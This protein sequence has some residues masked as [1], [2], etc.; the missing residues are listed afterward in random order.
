MINLPTNIKNFGFVERE[1]INQKYLL[2]R[3]GRDFLYYA[4]HYY[5]PN[6]FNP[7]K[8]NPK[9]IESKKLFGFSIPAVFAWTQF[10]F[11]NLPK[12]LKSKSLS[13]KINNKQIDTF[14]DFLIA[15]LFSRIKYVE[16]VKKVE[17]NVKRG[18]V[19]GLDI[20]MAF[21]GLLDHVLFVYG[22]DENY[23]Y[24]CDTRKVPLIKYEKVEKNSE[25]YFMKISKLEVKKRW[26]RFSRIWLIEK[27]D[28]KF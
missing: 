23:F 16:A 20:A 25:V 10:Q 18:N 14:V 21:S 22:F 28:K 5:Y 12:F 15:V 7:S 2:N 17:E 27:F 4:L 6:D 13:L 9:I 3:C 24:V 26:K 11:L 8:N 1:K 19:V